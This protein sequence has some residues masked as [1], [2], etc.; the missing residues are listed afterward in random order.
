[1]A[2]HAKAKGGMIVLRPD[3]G[4]PVTQVL[5]ALKVGVGMGAGVGGWVC[6][7]VYTSMY[8]CITH[9]QCVHVYI[10][11]EIHTMYMYML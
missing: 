4:D 1:V 5:K 9:S 2:D 3:S 8:I 6:T 7:Y 10:S 11:V